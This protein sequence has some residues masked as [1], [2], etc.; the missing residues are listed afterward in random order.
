MGFVLSI[1]QGTTNTKALLVGRDGRPAFRVSAPLTLEHP[2]A[3]FAEQDPEEIW[4]SVV[5]VVKECVAFAGG[6]IEGVAIANQRETA[7]AWERKTGRAVAPAMS[8]QCRRSIAVCERLAAQAARVKELSGL[9]LDPLLSGTK[10]AWLLENQPELRGRAEAGEICFGTVDSWLIWKLTGGAV[11]ACDATN[12]S[13]TGL[14]N[15][16]TAAWDGELA[17]MFGVPMLAL[18]EVQASSGTFG[19]CAVEG[20]AGT[21]LVAAIGDSH[22]ALIGHG[23][24]QPGTVKAT[25]GTGSS[26]MTVT[27]GVAEAAGLANTIAWTTKAGVQYALEGNISMA[28]ASVQWVGEFLGL[29]RPVQDAVT[30]AATVQDSGG[31]VFV[32]GMAGLGAP[33]WRPAAR[34]VI[35]GLEAGSK[36]AHLARAAVEAIA[37]QV[38]DV[39]AAMEEGAEVELPALRADGGATRNDEL[40]QLQADLLG[41][42]VLRSACEDLSALGAAWL[43]GLELGWW[44]SMSDFASLPEE[45]ARFEPRMKDGERLQRLDAWHTAVKRALLEAR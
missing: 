15:L 16:R 38:C 45:A 1:D 27:T 9:P 40:M 17:K 32:P 7:L 28:G 35:A 24:A 2:Q 10:W 18:P 22:G 33:H 19:E 31:V 26:L 34:G 25:Y 23:R 12:A 5:Q 41:R 3:G 14:L 39:F 8:W 44:R 36:A 29:A 42:L 20:L 43:G 6:G 4:A 21:P 30:L 37:F 13:R 11:H